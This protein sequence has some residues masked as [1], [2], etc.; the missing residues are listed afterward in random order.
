MTES[1]RT[2]VQQELFEPELFQQ[3]SDDFW[4]SYPYLQPLLE[5]IKPGQDSDGR[6]A[7]AAEY[8]WKRDITLRALMSIILENA[9]SLLSPEAGDPEGMRTNLIGIVKEALVL[10]S[11][12]KV[13][14]DEL[15][16]A[17]RKVSDLAEAIR[18]RFMPRVL[19]VDDDPNI[20]DILPEVI[21]SKFPRAE[22]RTAATNAEALESLGGFAADLI[23]TDCNRP[24]GN[25]FELFRE[26]RSMPRFSCTPVVL[27]SGWLNSVSFED[28]DG[29]PFNAVLAK[30]FSQEE[31]LGTITRLLDA[32]HDFELRP[33]DENEG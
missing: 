10:T 25:G 12:Q 15:L 11:W 26:V 13:R 4:K 23:T 27:I 8:L 1:N 24:G 9:G 6:S 29:P 31:F 20:R 33:G 30:P 5:G 2:D 21:R 7:S 14:A 22:I 28:L 17:G 19:V 16:R 18:R 3:A 32:T